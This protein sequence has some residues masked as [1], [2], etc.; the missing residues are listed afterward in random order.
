MPTTN[1]VPS[2]DPSDLLFNAGKLDEVVNSTAPTYT[3]RMGV[4]RRTLTALEDEFPNA[5]AN[6][7]A[8]AASAVDA[9]DYAQA[10]QDE[11]A[12]AAEQAGAADASRVAAETARDAAQLAAGVYATTAAGLAAT[13][14]GQYFNVPASSA[15]D[16]LILYLNSSG[17]A[18]E[19]KRY[20]SAAAFD[21]LYRERLLARRAAFLARSVDRNRYAKRAAVLV[22]LGQSNNVPRGTAI[23]GSVSRDV[24]MPVA[25]DSTTYWPFNSLSAEMCGNWTDLASAVVDIQG[26]SENPGAGMALAILGGTFS[27]VYM[28]SVSKGST[29][30]DA[31][32]SGGILS[33]C[34]AVI[35]RLCAIARADGFEPVVVF[36][37]HHGETD[38][39]SS[40][41]EDDYYSK[42]WAYYRKVQGFAAYAMGDVS[43]DAPIVFHMP[44]AY[45]TFGTA[46]NMR[47]VARAIVRL[48]RD[49]PGGILLGGSYQFLASDGVHHVN[50]AIRQKGEYAGMLL[51]DYFAKGDTAQ[52]LQIVDA[53][54]S[55][56]TV[57][58]TF[59]KEIN[60][61]T[62]LTFGTS[63][64]PTNALGGFEF[65]DDGAFIKVMSITVQGRKAVLTLQ[66]APVGTTQTVQIASQTM[67]GTPN[68]FQT[69]A[70]SQIRANYTGPVGIYDHTKTYHELA[71]PQ[72]IEARP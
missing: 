30:I 22:L 68:T 40:M 56:T 61:D 71:A 11:A 69:I 28:C 41:S 20:P 29:G 23:S 35:N 64:N 57:T 9:A 6:A 59:N 63:L 2:T 46:T 60:Y 31:L 47:N 67:T 32:N 26:A 25:G 48:A 1:P 42:A 44:I 5:A 43:Y 36:D 70:G 15:N 66:T 65:L 62:G 13:T 8:A 14:N 53:V 17:T 16:S 51:R 39:Y 58:V 72:T 37:T 19:Q 21:E 38:A 45:G 33:N 12:V 24:Y 52:C 27:R 3:D 34:Y 54:W 49:L 50:T 7:A 18:V 4:E 10:A 55:G